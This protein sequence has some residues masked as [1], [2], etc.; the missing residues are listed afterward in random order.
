MAAL[1]NSPS[2]NKLLERIQGIL[3][4]TPG[5]K[6][7]TFFLARS[8]SELGLSSNFLDRSSLKVDREVPEVFIEVGG[9]F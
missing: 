2:N 6:P 3:H 7:T 1:S 4:R 5:G 8:S 9:F